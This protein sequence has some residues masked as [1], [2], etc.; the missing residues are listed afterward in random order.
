MNFKINQRYIKSFMIIYSILNTIFL[1]INYIYPVN[2]LIN[3]II[4]SISSLLIILIGSSKNISYNNYFKQLFLIYL[5]LFISQIVIDNLFIKGTYS[6]YN[7]III[8]LT[9]PLWIISLKMNK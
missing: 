6:I 5:V 2:N 7:N 1:F 4:I 3:I 9:P 8:A